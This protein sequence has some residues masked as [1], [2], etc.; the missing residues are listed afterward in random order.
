LKI[1]NIFPPEPLAFL[2]FFSII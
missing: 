2:G 1:N